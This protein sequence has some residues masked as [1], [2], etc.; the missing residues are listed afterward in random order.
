MIT[1]ANTR[2]YV[3]PVPCSMLDTISLKSDIFFQSRINCN[4]EA[5]SDLAS[6]VH[7]VD[8]LVPLVQ[9]LLHVLQLPGQCNVLRSHLVKQ[10]TKKVLIKIK[11]MLLKNTSPIS[12]SHCK[13]TLLNIVEQKPKRNTI[14][15]FDWKFN[16]N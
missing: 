5:Y 4:K 8:P 15:N 1:S 16:C 7:R 13:K 11:F 10:F 12:L 6:F 9:L 3:S 2:S 14:T